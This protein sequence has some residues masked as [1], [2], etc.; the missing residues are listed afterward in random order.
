MNLNSTLRRYIPFGARGTV[1]G[2]T[3]EKL[4]VMFD[5]QFLHGNNI[6]GHCDNYRGA[7]VNPEYLMNLSKEF[8]RLTKENYKAAQ[9]FYEKPIEGMP[10][11]SDELTDAQKTENDEVPAREKFVKEKR[12]YDRPKV[13]KRQQDQPSQKSAPKQ[14][15]PRI[16][17]P[18]APKDKSELL[19]GAQKSGMNTNVK[20]FK[21]KQ[22][23][24]KEEAKA[25]Q[26]QQPKVI[27]I[28]QPKAKPLEPEQ[29]SVSEGPEIILGADSNPNEV[30]SSLFGGL[31]GFKLKDPSLLNQPKW[32]ELEQSLG[33]APENKTN[34]ETKIE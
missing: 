9:R 25:V 22:Y 8:A 6:Y 27:H 30:K 12:N 33:K 14:N 19:E 1:V 17:Q 34:P 11:F 32:Q 7:Q 24:Q 5:E 23:K 20:E 2:R 4:V 29:I 16:H 15:A 28:Y 21:P 31:P 3:E 10:L 13:Q 26:S 18:P